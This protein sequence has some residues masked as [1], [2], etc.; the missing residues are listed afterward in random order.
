MTKPSSHPILP[1][2]K[3]VQRSNAAGVTPICPCSPEASQEPPPC[4]NLIP[5]APKAE[6][7]RGP[8][9]PSERQEN[10]PQPVP[11]PVVHGQSH[12]QWDLQ[13]SCYC[14]SLAPMGFPIRPLQTISVPVNWLYTSECSGHRAADSSLEQKSAHF[15]HFKLIRLFAL[16]STQILRL[17]HL[18]LNCDVFFALLSLYRAYF[19]HTAGSW[20]LAIR[21]QFL[22]Y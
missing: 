18:P 3:G 8:Q 19:W 16:M 1:T 2:A 22:K 14:S 7:Q 20:H 10:S 13:A 15:P 21:L 4:Q 6:W 12:C 11:V 17:K 9:C 5:T